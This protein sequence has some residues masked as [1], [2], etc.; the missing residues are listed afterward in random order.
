MP[1]LNA[2]TLIATSSTSST[3]IRP[4]D[5]GRP[6]T[7]S[8]LSV[9]PQF[10][11]HQVADRHIFTDTTP[12][13]FVVACLL[14]KGPSTIGYD[15]NIKGGFNRQD[16][17][18]YLMA[19]RGASKVRIDTL[20][21]HFY[22]SKNDAG[23]LSMIEFECIVT[24]PVEARMRFME[25][26]CPAL[27][28]LSYA[29]NSPLFV[30]TIRIFDEIYQATH[31]VVV[32]PYRNQI[33]ADSLNELFIEMRPVYA[34]YREAKISPS[35]F[36]RFLCFYKIMEGL[37]GGLRSKAYERARAGGAIL[38]SRRL[39]VPDDSAVPSD[40]RQY[41]GRSIKAFFD[42]VLTAQ[43]RNAVAHLRT[44][45][46]VLDVSSPVELERFAGLAL[47]ADLCARDLIADHEQIL[48][49]LNASS[50]I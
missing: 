30:N 9:V 28:H 42:E 22:V 4:E 10:Q 46:G 6:G 15:Q 11:D 33:I 32:S 43:F 44:E 34:M 19:P 24:T 23:E 40:L 45:E 20:S 39:V 50:L 14:S 26:V 41:V 17:A 18:S 38:E 3:S 31:I 36:Y 12:R 1:N 47:V 37:L 48:M 49:Q 2:P 29:Y 35:D 8:L 25:T 5:L 16:G 7:H 21:G 27:D 13:Q